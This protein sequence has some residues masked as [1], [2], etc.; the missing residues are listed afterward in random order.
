MNR[1]KE[2]VIKAGRGLWNSFPVLIGVVLLISL[3]SNLIPKSAY[4]LLFSGN[5]IAD[6]FIGSLVGS[7][8]AG[9]PVTSYVLGGEF[10]NQGISL[11]AV[12]AFLVSW[13]TV[14]LVQLPAES[15]L[16]GKRFSI[17]RNITAFFFSIIVAIITTS[18]VILV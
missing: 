11:L 18:V 2:A 15:M 1:I 5:Y 17:T 16:L 6:S 12:T 7:I 4:S 8:L 14:G 10:L 3:I 9:N 13:V